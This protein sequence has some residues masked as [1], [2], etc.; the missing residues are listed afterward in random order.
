MS[1]PENREN[2]QSLQDTIVWAASEYGV[3]TGTVT[4][5][6]DVTSL[7]K[8]PTNPPVEGFIDNVYVMIFTVGTDKVHKNLFKPSTYQGTD[9]LKL[10]YVW[11]NDGG[12]DDEDTNV[13]GQ[14]T[15]KTTTM[16]DSLSGNT[17]TLSIEDTY[18]SAT[19]H[20][21][22]KSGYM[23]IPHAD[24]VDKECIFIQFS[25]ETPSGAALTCE[26]RLI[27]I[28]ITYEGRALA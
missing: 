8:N 17:G 24:L 27:G 28:C 20:I 18:T 3:A 22:H 5:N 13:K 16:G 11:T 9:G 23:T 15:Y 25:F 12:V 26:P 2:L 14:I 10:S 7:G 1:R 21:E 19:G 6:I 4:E